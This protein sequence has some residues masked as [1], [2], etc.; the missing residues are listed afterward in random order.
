MT[1]DQWRA[2]SNAVLYSVQFD[3]E[4]NDAVLDRVIRLLFEQP[5][6]DL[7]PEDEYNGLAQAVRSPDPLTG[8]IP[9]PHSDHEFR[10][11]L[12]RLLDRLD[13]MRPWPQLPYQSLSV[14]KWG[15]FAGARPIARIG[16]SYVKAQE[17]LKRIFGRVNDGGT[18]EVLL[19][20]LRSGAEVALVGAPGAAEI[21]VLQRLPDRS[22]GQAPG[23][24]LAEFASATGFRPDEI[25]PLP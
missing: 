7:T 24:A 20:R 18:R 9:Q 19:L 13:A 14:S 5:M 11:F 12:R 25:T 2:V 10:G 3:R 15:E 22:P 21:T 23:Q 17:R 6:W 16:L 4:L 1:D 8:D